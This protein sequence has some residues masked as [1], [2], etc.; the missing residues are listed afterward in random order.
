V[1][2]ENDSGMVE[3]STEHLQ[4]YPRSSPRKQVLGYCQKLLGVKK[5]VHQP[6]V[7]KKDQKIYGGRQER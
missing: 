3:T 4:E 2:G 1:E 6:T 7:P 5:I